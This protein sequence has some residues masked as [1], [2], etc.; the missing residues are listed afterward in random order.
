[1][2]MLSSQLQRKFIFSVLALAGILTIGTAGYWLI[3]R[4]EYSFLDCMYMTIITISTIGYGE[5]VDL[6]NNPAGRVF[7]I[8]VALSGIGILFY[9]ITN[10]TAFVVEGAL[11]DSFRR[12]KMEKLAKNLEDHYIICGAGRLG[13]T[14]ANELGVDKRPYVL[15]EMDKEK[16]EKVSDVSQDSIMITGD[17]TDD[18][19]MV[20]AGIDKAKGLFAVTGDDNQNLV[21]CITAKQLNPNLRLVARCNE[22]KHIAKMQKSGADAV[23]SPDFIGGLR[24][25][26]EMIRPSVVSFLDIMLK[27]KEK[28]L[29]IEEV[30]V[31][32]SFSDKPI[33]ALN[34]KKHQDVLLLAVK[35]GKDWVYNPAEDYVVR[36]GNTL[37]FMSTPGERFDMEKIFH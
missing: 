28:N 32:E 25:A 20:K 12:R 34:L 30:F 21:I 15:V 1:M 7:T 26:S 16:T 35:A 36:P 22:T 19:T 18:S 27:D 23:V 4:G 2:Y 14:I 29:R 13:F 33:S 10:F 6:S 9:I 24:M 11:T 31:P 8:F 3:G 37:V 17:A 5:I